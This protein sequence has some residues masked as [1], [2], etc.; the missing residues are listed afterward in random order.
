LLVVRVGARR[1]KVAS[2]LME[3]IRFKDC[4]SE[5]GCAKTTRNNKKII[6]MK[7]KLLH[8]NGHSVV[9]PGMTC[10][11]IGNYWKILG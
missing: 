7:F 9:R 11:P 6:I 10:V 2:I 4:K 3:R 1:I 5:R 8:V